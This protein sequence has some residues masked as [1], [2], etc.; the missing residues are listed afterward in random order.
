MRKNLQALV[1]AAGEGTRFRSDK[2]KILH[3]LLGKSMLRLV[4]DSVLG[5]K[6]EKVFLV[7]GYQKEDVLQE[8]ASQDI[9]IVH[10]KVLEGTIHAFLAAKSMLNKFKDR[11][12]LVLGAN[13]PLL[14]TQ[15]LTSLLVFHRKRGNTV[16]RAGSAAE[17]PAVAVLKTRDL[18]WA[19]PHAVRRSHKSPSN[20]TEIIEKLARAG[21]KVED[22]SPRSPEDFFQVRTR[23]DL[24]RAVGV[25]RE[26]KMAE[27]AGHGVTV[28]DPSS[29]WID[30]AVQIGRDSSVY[31]A[32]VIEGRTSIGNG[33]FI[34]PGVHIINSQIG[35]RVRVFGSSVIDGATVEDDVQVGPFARLR[36]KTILR[37][38]SRIGN[39]VEVKNTDFG[40]GSKALHLSY[41]GDSEV[42]EGV[43]IGAGT[44]TCNYDGVKKN[45]TTIEAKAFIG[46]GT[47]L[48]APVRI[49]RGAY[50]GAGSVITKDVSPEALAVARSRQVERPGWA[51][52]KKIKR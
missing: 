1:L 7:V 10:Q 6:P 43:N 14:R 17:D 35:S 15:A 39:F 38:G 2:T 45:K 20:L 11:D 23:H 26:R 27:L 33:C 5:M 12:V 8:M 50:V 37:S 46:S 22:F 34:Y 9:K 40:R 49:G 42:H 30:L 51:R 18:L 3:P 48:V 25:L 29:T 41:L 21:K 19:L 32:V 28:Y 44:I 47:E 4:C 13:L 36:P 24:A 31:P 52:R 16:T